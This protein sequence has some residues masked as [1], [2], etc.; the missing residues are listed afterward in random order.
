MA[1]WNIGDKIQNRWEIHKILGGAGKSGMG[2][3]YVVYDHEFKEILAAKTFQDEAFRKNPAL[4]EHFVRE[5]LTW[6]NLDVHLN[7]AQARMVHTIAGKPFLFLE[8]VSG[9]D[10]GTWIGKPRLLGDIPQILRFALQFCDGM[11]HARTKGLEA[12]RD[13]KPANCLVT[14]DAML[15]LVDGSSQMLS[16]STE[17]ATLKVTDFGL[18]KALALAE[19]SGGRGGTPEYMPPEQ[20]DN[21]AAADVRA[22]VYSFGVMLYEMITGQL[23]FGGRSQGVTSAELEVR[24]KRETPPSVKCQPGAINEIIQTCMAKD[25]AARFPTFE[26]VRRQLGEIYSGMTGTVFLPPLPGVVLDAEQ[27]FNKGNGLARLGRH[28]EAISCFEKALQIQPDRVVGWQA[29]G[30]ALAS[31]GKVAEALAAFDHATQLNPNHPGPWHDKGTLLSKCGRNEEALGCF[32]RTLQ[33]DPRSEDAWRAKSSA[34]VG[35]KRWEEALRCC[36]RALEINPL[37]GRSWLMK[38]FSLRF[39]RRGSEVVTC[40]ARA[41][42]IDPEFVKTAENAMGFAPGQPERTPE[43][44]AASEALAAECF[45]KGLALEGA[46]RF[47]EAIAAYQRAI[48][49]APDFVKAWFNKGI[50]L[51][52]VARHDEAIVCFDQVLRLKPNDD[53]AWLNKGLALEQAGRWPAAVDC[54]DRGIEANPGNVSAWEL[55]GMALYKHSGR[56]QEALNCFEEAERLGATGL[57]E[58]IKSCRD[59]THRLEAQASS[60]ADLEADR[61]CYQAATLAKT[62]NFKEA[63]ECIDRALKA[64]PGFARAWHLKGATLA[65]FGRMYAAVVCLEEARKAGADVDAAMAY[66]RKAISAREANIVPNSPQAAERWYEKGRELT[67][68]SRWDESLDCFDRALAIQPR[69]GKLWLLKACV[70]SNAGRMEA[71]LECAEQA[72]RLGD[73]QAPMVIAKCRELITRPK[74]PAQD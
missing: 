12:H 40:V 67:L 44:R 35:L 56:A 22:D 58:V 52:S 69:M 37:D 20:W 18:A 46:R 63:I 17:D 3:V 57:A 27:W 30:Q 25:P 42:E 55:K 19:G 47:E 5:V 53:V 6:V 11:I 61:L 28:Q 60:P 68:L 66:C 70:L 1:T 33:L 16:S 13:V 2:I 21:F 62:G 38:A 9:G 50:S 32:D 49:L 74:G 41:R 72:R 15:K 24:H 7:V 26:E 10:L 54:F 48:D 43:T 34:F 59:W 8:Y 65:D 29:K 23:P 64:K 31:Q 73:L 4:R 45:Q 36:E 39:L 71:A 14:G 51:G